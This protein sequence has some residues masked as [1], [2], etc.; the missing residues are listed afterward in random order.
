MS[1]E[2]LL[3]CPCCQSKKSVAIYKTAQRELTSSGKIL[4]SEEGTCSV[5]GLPFT[6]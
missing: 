3:D 6:T 1:A 2:E 4:H 5:C